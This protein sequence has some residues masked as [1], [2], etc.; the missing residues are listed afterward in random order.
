[1]ARRLVDLLLAAAALCALWPLLLVAAVAVR[2]SSPGPVLYRA[3]RSGRDAVEFDLFKLRTMHV[4]AE[5]GARITAPDDA[6]IF[7]VGRWLRL[8]KIDEL[9]Q[10]VNVL[11]G[12][13][14][15]VGPRPE[16][17]EVVRSAYRDQDRVTLTVRPGLASP[18]SL[19]AYTHGDALL[20]GA[21][22]DAYLTRLLPVKL[23]LD[24]EYVRRASLTYDLRVMARTIWIIAARLAGR[25]QF[26]EPPE[27]AGV[28]QRTPGVAPTVASRLTATPPVTE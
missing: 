20:D 11:R 21:V 28:R 2:C 17:P 1:M 22:E 10:L 3:R 4:H 19:Y 7:R 12:E 25:R 6:R 9:P 13:M 16:D 27:M 26:R 18:G 24:A 14:A 15:I 5:G 8:S 23:A